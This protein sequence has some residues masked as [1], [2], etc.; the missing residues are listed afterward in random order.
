MWYNISMGKYIYLDKDKKRPLELKPCSGCSEEK[1][2]SAY[3]KFCSSECSYK[4]RNKPDL[5]KNQEGDRVKDFNSRW[6]YIKA[7]PDRL[8]KHRERS[9]QDK[10][11]VRQWLAEYKSSFGCIDCGYNIH[12]AALQLDHNGPKT[13]SISELRSSIRRMQEEIK[14]GNCVVRCSNCHAIKTWCEKNDFNY[15]PEDYR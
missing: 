6:D 1:L 9:S 5:S 10:K 4:Y 2:I 11:A 8:E 14:N 12:F 15:N 3:G 13:A 7:N